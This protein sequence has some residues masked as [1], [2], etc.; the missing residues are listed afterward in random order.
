MPDL[1]RVIGQRFHRLAGEELPVP[2]AEAVIRRGR[3]RRRRARARAISAIAAAAAVITAI[4]A[5]QLAASPAARHP[6]PASHGRRSPASAV[7]GCPAASSA[8]LSAALHA[9]PLAISYHQ[10][11]VSPIAL[12]RD[13]TALWVQ[14]TAPG[15]HGIAEEDLQ[16]GAIVAKIESLPADYTGAQGG[17]GVGGVLVWANTYPTGSDLG[18]MT[19]VQMW[20]PRTGVTTLEPTGQHRDSLSNPV[21][22]PGDKLAAWEVADGSQQEIIEANLDTGVADVVAH[23]YLGA[24]VFVGNA[25]VWSV[26]SE[27]SEP[28]GS[29]PTHLVAV[30]AAEFPASQRIA[31]PVAL[32]GFSEDVAYGYGRA[33]PWQP[34]HSLIASYGGAVV[35]AS[36][37]LLKLYYSPSPSQPARLVIT[38]PSVGGTVSPDGIYLGPGY[39]GWNTASAGSYLASTSSFAVVRVINET[40]IWGSVQGLSSEV[41]VGTAPPTKKPH[42]TQYRLVSGSTIGALRCAGK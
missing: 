2:P 28:S 6:A 20:S 9:R 3:Q 10:L 21:F 8:A 22:G 41:L 7:L 27:P 31:V 18:A 11:R 13:G 4:A 37:D 36:A 17:L 33:G 25:L 39:I 19:P 26:S 42:P 32:R 1:D 38:L 29:A 30:N 5:S 16:T 40:T 34:A 15:F 14:T 35:Y 24:P 23:G 12:A